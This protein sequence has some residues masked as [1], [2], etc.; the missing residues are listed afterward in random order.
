MAGSAHLPSELE[1]EF[2]RAEARA[3][4]VLRA[5]RI[6]NSAVNFLL[7]SFAAAVICAFVKDIPLMAIAFVTVVVAIL[8]YLVGGVLK[9]WFRSRLI[10]TL[11]R[12]E[13]LCEG[14]GYMVPD[15]YGG[16]KQAVVVGQV[17]SK[18]TVLKV[19]LWGI[20]SAIISAL[21][22]RPWADIAQIMFGSIVLFFVYWCYPAAVPEKEA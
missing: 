10:R 11:E 15:H 6:H 8:F 19:V 5:E 7:I 1:W 12:I 3:R 22:K 16:L 20:G 18:A 17:K 13:T 9:F 2:E 21:M 14:G 4:R